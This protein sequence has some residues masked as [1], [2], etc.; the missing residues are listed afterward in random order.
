[1]TPLLLKES[2]KIHSVKII[3]EDYYELKFDFDK[4]KP[5]YHQILYVKKRF[6][7][8]IDKKKIVSVIAQIDEETFTEE[9]RGKMHEI[10]KENQH[11][12][13]Y[14]SLV[15]KASKV[16]LPQLKTLLF[17]SKQFMT[18]DQ[19]KLYITQFNQTC[20]K[21]AQSVNKGLTQD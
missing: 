15:E 17:N 19:K 10:L 20:A 4:T 16:E 7:R 14:K 5:L 18:N 11:Y 1:M 6:N 3:Q 8:N 12:K 13:L 2:Y 21:V 9:Q